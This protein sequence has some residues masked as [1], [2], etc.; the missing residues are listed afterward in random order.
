[1]DHGDDPLSQ[2]RSAPDHMPLNAR[3]CL[4]VRSRNFCL[5]SDILY[6]KGSDGI[7]RRA[8]R[9]FEK[10]A[11]LQEAHQGIA[12]GHYAGESTARKV[13]QSG[14]WWPTTKKDAHEFC[15]QCD[16]CQRLGQPMEQARMPHQPILP[17][18]PFQKW[19][20][21]FVGPFKPPAARTGNKYIIVATDYCTKWVEA[22]AL[23]DNT[24]ASTA[25]FVYEHLW[26]RYGCPIELVSD[27]GG[28][29]INHIIRELTHHYAVVHKKSTP[30]YPQA[31]GLAES[32]NKILQTILKKIVNENRTDWDN[33][34]QSALWAYR[35]SFKTSIQS[36]P[37]RMAFGLEAVM[38]IEFQV[39]SLRVQVKA[40][41]PEA[42]SEQYRLEQL[43]ELGEDRITSMAQLEQRQRQR[44][45]FVD[46]HR[47]G[48]EKELSIGKP[49]LLFQTRLGSMPGKLRFRWT[50]PFWIIDEFN[51]TFQLGTLAGDI[52]KSWANGFRLRPYRGTTPP[53]PFTET[54]DTDQLRDNTTE[55]A[56]C[57]PR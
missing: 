5:V 51:G 53:N 14:L 3:K 33:K 7:W 22:K 12:G 46:R 11:I 52:V 47:K 48:L 16:L 15:R 27:Q 24:A 18:D 50:G 2:Y 8:I 55:E 36:T 41:L 45:A 21:D 34:L 28:H 32:T 56:T 30:Y 44:K 37:F 9:H 6:H 20:L 10:K 42:Q 13:W 26:C 43:L 4:A 39:P 38:P 23:R 35:T 31:N 49:V 19:G 17:L 57:S 25:K 29:F 40:R 1:M 54:H